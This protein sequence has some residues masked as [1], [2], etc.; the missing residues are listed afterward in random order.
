MRFCERFLSAYKSMWVP[1]KCNL[2]LSA[3]DELK[4]ALA[5]KPA[6]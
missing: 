6:T 2:S 4:H 3:N 1:V 5:A